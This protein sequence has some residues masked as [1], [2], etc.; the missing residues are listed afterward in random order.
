[1]N[2][3]RAEC[4]STALIKAA[5]D[6][7]IGRIETGRLAYLTAAEKQV[8]QEFVHRQAKQRETERQEKWEKERADWRGRLEVLRASPCGVCHHDRSDAPERGAVWCRETRCFC[9]HGL[10]EASLIDPVRCEWCHFAES[11]WETD[12]ASV[13]GLDDVSWTCHRSPP[14]YVVLSDGT[15]AGEWPPVKP[16]GWC[17]EFRDDGVDHKAT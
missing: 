5:K 2:D 13:D 9:K 11:Y 4:R 17:G 16:N 8:A 14:T 12:G 1:M 10:E 7:G 6:L 3:D 15:M